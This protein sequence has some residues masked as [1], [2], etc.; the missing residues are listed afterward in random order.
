MMV[1]FCAGFFP[2]DVL[3]EILDLIESVSGGFPTFSFLPM[4]QSSSFLALLELFY[5]AHGLRKLT[6]GTQSD[7]NRLQT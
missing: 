5:L 3:D 4:R 2:G 1:S 6:R 7:V